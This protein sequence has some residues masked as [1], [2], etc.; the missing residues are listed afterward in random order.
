MRKLLT[1]MLLAAGLAAGAQTTDHP[2]NFQKAYLRNSSGLKTV[3]DYRIIFYAESQGLKDE[4]FNL[5][6]SRLDS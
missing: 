1:M 5:I 6:D 2:D 4:V 3:K